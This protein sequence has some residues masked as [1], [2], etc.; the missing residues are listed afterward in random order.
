MANPSYFF[1]CEE[2]QTIGEL[3]LIGRWKLVPD[4]LKLIDVETG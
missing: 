4:H 2:E 1:E 3:H